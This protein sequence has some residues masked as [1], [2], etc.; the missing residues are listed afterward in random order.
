MCIIMFAYTH[1]GATK[2]SPKAPLGKLAPSGPK[3]PFAPIGPFGVLGP[4]VDR[5]WAP[6]EGGGWCVRPRLVHLSISIE[7]GYLVSECIIL[8][9]TTV[10]PQK[11]PKRPFSPTGPFGVMGATQ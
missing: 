8:Y 10:E 5:S 9:A 7:M 4:Q 6:G 11:K 3:G 2:T 1:H